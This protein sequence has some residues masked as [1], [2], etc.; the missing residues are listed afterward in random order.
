MPG[1]GLFPHE[2]VAGETADDRRRAARDASST[3]RGARSQASRTTRAGRGSTPVPSRSAASSRASATTAS[4]ATRAS[5]S[6]APSAPTCTA[7]CCR[8]TRGSPTGCSRRRSPTRPVASHPSSS[9]CRTGWR[10]R[11]TR[12]QRSGRE[13]AAAGSSGSGE[14]T[15]AGR[16][17]GCGVQSERKPCR[18][19][20][21][22][23]RRSALLALLVVA[24]CADDPAG[25]L[26]RLNPVSAA[27]CDGSDRL[28]GGWTRA[29]AELRFRRLEPAQ[30]APTESFGLGRM[31]AAAGAS[32][33][34]RSSAS[35]ID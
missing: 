29:G 9:R 35:D 26:A 6:A 1:I 15:L 25:D 18:C 10:R 23:D 20:G 21:D 24:G 34:R 2:T 14:S 31:S 16:P 33:T 3:A 8:G 32:A 17:S 13:T 28:S 19:S 22:A 30:Q 12:C 27:D 11:R 5:A 7:R 4:R